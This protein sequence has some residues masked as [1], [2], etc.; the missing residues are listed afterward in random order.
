MCSNMFYHLLVPRLIKPLELIATSLFFNSDKQIPSD[1]KSNKQIQVEKD[2][3]SSS[4]TSQDSDLGSMTQEV[5]AEVTSNGDS[6][7][8]H[9]SNNQDGCSLQEGRNRDSTRSGDSSRSSLSTSTADSKGRG[10]GTLG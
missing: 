6:V 10:S 7:S 9:S 1:L 8:L 5:E 4:H 2:Q 3:C